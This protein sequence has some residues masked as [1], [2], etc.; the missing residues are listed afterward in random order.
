MS[1]TQE[2]LESTRASQHA[3]CVL[4]GSENPLGFRLRFQVREDRSV[5]VSFQCNELFQSYPGIIHGGVVAALLDAAMTCSG[6]R[7]PS[8][9]VEC[10]CRSA[11]GPVAPTSAGAVSGGTRTP[12]RSTPVANG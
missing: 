10:M 6:A 4:C 9:A 2:A 7:E 12:A 5:Q 11:R 1:Q 3:R 8:E